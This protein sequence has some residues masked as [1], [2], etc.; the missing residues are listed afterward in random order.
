LANRRAAA[1][2]RC[3]ESAKC[4]RWFVTP[5]NAALHL[6]RAL[7]SCSQREYDLNLALSMTTADCVVASAH[8]VVRSGRSPRASGFLPPGLR[9][10]VTAG[11]ATVIAMQQ[12]RSV[13]LFGF[14]TRNRRRH[15]CRADPSPAPARPHRNHT[16]DDRP[17]FAA[18]GA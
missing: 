7:S 13:F 18:P 10:K 3:R 1:S 9:A 11:S 8:G 15:E 12:A 5:A 2:E 17:R 14:K 6:K 16:R 4:A